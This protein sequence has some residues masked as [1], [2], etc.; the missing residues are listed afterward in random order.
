MADRHRRVPLEEQQRDRFS[1][2]VRPSHDQR[3]S[4]RERRLG[5]V[6]Q[7]QNA[8][9]RTGPQP[10]A[11]GEE[12]AGV[13]RAEPVDV[14]LRREQIEHRLRIDLL[15]KRQLHQHAVHVRIDVQPP[16]QRE[17][18]G[19]GRLLGQDVLEARHPRLQAGLRLSSDVDLA[20]RIVPDPD[21]RQPRPRAGARLD[22]AHLLR[23]LG[24]HLRGYGFAV[25]DHSGSWTQA[26]MLWPSG[27][28]TNAP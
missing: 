4:A 13:V 9:R 11:P 10:L 12:G 8:E 25:D 3:L 26:S 17:Q 15:G 21:Q 22:L 18:L 7:P 5:F 2:D 24:A 6:E 20:R 1:D 14:L 19:L 16:D 23:A 27:S 28:S